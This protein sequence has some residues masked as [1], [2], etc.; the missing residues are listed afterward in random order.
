MGAPLRELCKEHEMR[1]AKRLDGF[2]EQLESRLLFAVGDMD[3][4]FG[5]LRSLDIAGGNDSGF[6]VAMQSDGKAIVAG[7]TQSAGGTGNDFFVARFNIDGT[8]D[9]TFGVGGV[10]VTDFGSMSDGA[11]AMAIQPD[12]K[13]VVAGESTRSGSSFDFAVARY[14]S[15][16]SLDQTFG[17]GGK[18]IVDFAGGFD[19]AKAVALVSGGG[20]VIAGSA[21]IGG[22]SQF[23]L[24]KLDSSGQL[25]STFSGSGKVMTAYSPGSSAAEAVAVLSDGSLVVAGSAIDF[26]DEDR[27]YAAVKFAADGTLDTTFGDAGWSLVDMGGDAES[28]QTIILQN[29][30]RIVLAGDSCSTVAGQSDFSMT[31]LMGDGVMDGSFG[32]AGRLMTDYHSEMDQAMTAVQQTDGKIVL[33]GMA[34]VD[35]VYRI[36]M[37]RYSSDGVLDATFGVGGKVIFNGGVGGEVANAIAMAAD[38]DWIVAGFT[39]DIEGNTDALI[40]RV[41]GDSV[42]PPPEPPAQFE[43]KDDA[44]NPGKKILVFN[45]STGDDHVKFRFTRKHGIEVRVNGNKITEKFTNI[46]RIVAYGNDGNDWIVARFADVPVHFFGGVGNDRLVGGRMGDILAGGDGNDDLRGLRGNDLIIGGMGSD[47]L[48]GWL[49]DDLLI[50]GVL[51]GESDLAYLQSLLNMWNQKKFPLAWRVAGLIGGVVDD[52]AVDRFHATPCR[53]GIVAGVMDK[54]PKRR[55]CW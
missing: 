48:H 25:D 40:A 5:G 6:T 36:A 15:A 17:N 12:G 43:L 32:T 26:S 30:G 50:G 11:Y 39:S 9:N 16:G 4:S 37:S 22:V 7:R 46:S 8:L 52:Y 29:S 24:L 44:A 23:A 14:T 21:S 45:G 3:S 51:T 1:A 33:A 19:Q 41:L 55:W 47:A 53:D 10:V 54:T 28:A 35:G 13:I 20:I 2:I 18:L 34:S 38:G 42:V 49:G 27:D 31:R